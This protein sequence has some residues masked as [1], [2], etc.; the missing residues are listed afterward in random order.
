MWPVQMT[1]ALIRDLL[2]QSRRYNSAF[3]FV[4]SKQETGQ[5]PL[6][7]SSGELVER[8]NVEVLVTS[9]L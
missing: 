9:E 5:W 4:A 6:A 1:V 7:F 2:W 3:L 8:W